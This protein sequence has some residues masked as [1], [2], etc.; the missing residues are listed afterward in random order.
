M[1][2]T[3]TVGKREAR[4]SVIIVP[5]ADQVNTSICPG[6]SIIIFSNPSFFSSISRT[7]SN[8][9]ANRLSEVIIAPFGPSLYLK[10]MNSVH[11]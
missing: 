9:V 2:Y 3:I 10:W 11:R 1:T 8:L 6:V 5:E 7:L 4:V